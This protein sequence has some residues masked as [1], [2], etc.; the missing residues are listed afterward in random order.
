M[1]IN[2]AVMEKVSLKAYAVKHKLSLFNVMKMV[3]SGKLK[4]IIEEEDGREIT[5]VILDE[6]TEKEVKESIIPIEDEKELNIQ[7]MVYAL[8]EEVKAL[9]KEVEMLKKSL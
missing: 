5:Y 6:E 3:K 9:K 2:G 7:T 4:S 1:K 8:K